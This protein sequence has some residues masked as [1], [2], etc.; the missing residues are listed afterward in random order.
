M[1]PKQ[2]VSNVLCTPIFRLYSDKKTSWRH[3]IQLS[4]ALKRF[5]EFVR[6]VNVSN[7][8]TP[9]DPNVPDYF[10][11]RE[12]LTVL[13][14]GADALTYRSCLRN[15]NQA[16]AVKQILSPGAVHNLANTTFAHIL[17]KGMNVPRG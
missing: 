11:T 13:L 17:R 15:I 6:T 16:V 8:A 7:E 4:D 10:F 1:Q 14:T 5:G 2:R 12:D 3:F 9:W